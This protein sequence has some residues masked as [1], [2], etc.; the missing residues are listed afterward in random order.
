MF[1]YPF[2]LRHPPFKFSIRSGRLLI[3]GCWTKFPKV[4]A[5]QGFAELAGM[6]DLDERGPETAVAVAGL[7]CYPECQI[8]QFLASPIFSS[9]ERRSDL[10][11][12]CRNR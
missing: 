9:E 3:S 12:C 8:P 2:A 11:V 6:L 4:K 10:R 1:V 7:D 5:H